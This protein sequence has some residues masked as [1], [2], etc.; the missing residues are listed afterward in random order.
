MKRIA[1]THLITDLAVGGAETMLSRLVSTMDR[2]AFDTRIISLTGIDVIGEHMLKQG[3]PVTELGAQR[4]SADPGIV[5]RLA[6]LL[7]KERPDILQTWMYHADLAGGLAARMTGRLPVVWNI[8][9]SALDPDRDS[10]KTMWTAK[11]C[12]RL[13]NLLPVRIVCC[14]EYSKHMH[15]R[16]GYNRDKMVVI[17]N[18]YDLDAFAPDEDSRRMIREELGLSLDTRLVG[19]VARFNPHKDHHTFCRAAGILHRKMT[20][21]RFVLCGEGVNRENRH[22]TAWIDE[23]GI[24]AVTHLLDLRTDIPTIQA[25]LDIATS[26]SLGEA[27][28]N[29]IAEA[30]TSGVPCVVTDAGDSA[31]I[32]GE[33]GLVVP[34]G[35][36]QALAGALE[37]LLSLTPDERSALGARARE[38]I[39]DNYELHT[40]TQRYQHMYRELAEAP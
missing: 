5:V 1:V 25:A 40:I 36:A 31:A 10:R 24:G 18:G 20:D 30:M 6:W 39:R 33:T 15:A 21:I 37:K 12:A 17:P 3:I 28:S 29:A 34:P 13:S 26:S 14:S 11:A 2:N 38:R 35:D 19:L 32:V 22:L 7:R 27:F 8:R 16:L 23:E 4:G 9:H